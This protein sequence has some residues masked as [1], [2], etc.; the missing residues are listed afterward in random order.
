MKRVI[1]LLIFTLI[2]ISCSERKATKNS[3]SNINLLE[4]YGLDDT[5]LVIG[6]RFD[7]VKPHHKLRTSLIKDDGVIDTKKL[8]LFKIKE[9]KLSTSQV[10]RLLES[11]YGDNP[12]YYLL[13]SDCHIPHHIFLFYNKDG[14][15]IN[16]IQVCFRC[17]ST[18]IKP[19]SYDGE[20][21][22]D[23]I[24]IAKI[25][26]ELELG[27]HEGTVQNYISVRQEGQKMEDEM[28]KRI[29]IQN[30]SQ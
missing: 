23:Y 5:T 24:T 26:G 27:M 14:K 9:A 15:I 10:N 19:S 8:E 18:L 17:S 30:K 13:K 7:S 21:G 29:K 11:V 4:Q 6:Y 20:N 25:C 2:C 3:E 16:Y 28:N 1:I 22:L 12:V